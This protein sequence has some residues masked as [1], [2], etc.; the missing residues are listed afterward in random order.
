M[1]TS[2]PDT[3]TPQHSRHP[4]WSLALLLSVL[5]SSGLF[6]WRLWVAAP[7]VYPRMQFSTTE[8]LNADMLNWYHT[9][10][11]FG[12]WI[13]ASLSGLL[14]WKYAS[15]P[16]LRLRPPISWA[17]LVLGVL[18][19]GFSILLCVATAI[20]AAPDSL[21]VYTS[22]DTYEVSL[23]QTYDY[24]P[25]ESSTL[26]LIVIRADGTYYS[27]VLDQRANRGSDETAI[28]T[29]LSIQRV[30]HRVYFRCNN[31]SISLRTPYV[32]SRKQTLYLGWG[33]ATEERRLDKLPFYQPYRVQCSPCSGTNE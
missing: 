29:T 33:K 30:D 10:S 21:G 9:T 3:R 26:E 16:L 18:G 19:L 14:F 20:F 4:H 13:I 11:L 1:P 24:D 23:A 27:E 2:Q 25:Y 17:V 6:F 28:C 22:V 5:V 7:N 15:F 32:D 31:E 8:R 12:I